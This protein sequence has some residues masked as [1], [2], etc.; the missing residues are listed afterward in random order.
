M[1]PPEPGGMPT[2][3]LLAKSGHTSVASL[4]RYALVSAGALRR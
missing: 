2:P 3:V 1:N 4:A